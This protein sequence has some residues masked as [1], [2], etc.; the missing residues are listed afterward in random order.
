MAKRTKVVT[1]EQLERG[2]L[3]AQVR[4]RILEMGA[5]DGPRDYERREKKALAALRI[6]ERAL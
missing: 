1:V 3:V 2:A 5:C 4:E 6:L